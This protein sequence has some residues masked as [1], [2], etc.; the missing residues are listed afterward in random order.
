MGKIQLNREKTQLREGSEYEIRTKD[1]GNP[2][3]YHNYLKVCGHTLKQKCKREN[4]LKKTL[5]KIIKDK[6]K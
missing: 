6:E 4:Q 2:T 3:K 5:M 1:I